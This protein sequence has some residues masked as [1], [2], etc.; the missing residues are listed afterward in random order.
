MPDLSVKT[1]LSDQRVRPSPGLRSLGVRSTRMLFVDADKDGISDPIEQL[2]AERFAPIIFIHP[3]EPNYPVSVEWLL[4]RTRLRYFEDCGPDKLEDVPNASPVGSQENL[5]GLPWAH[6]DDWGAGHPT[7]HCGGAP[8]HRRITSIEP[9]PESFGDQ[10]TFA[11]RDVQGNDRL[12]SLDPADWVT[13]VH[14]YPNDTGGITLQYWHLFAYNSLE[15]IVIGEHGGDWDGTVHVVLGPDLEP[16][17]AVYPR[18][19]ED[20]PGHV[21]DWGDL[22]L[23]KTTHPR[24]AIDAGG[25][26]SFKDIQDRLAFVN[27]RVPIAGFPIQAGVVAWFD[28]PDNPGSGAGRRTGGNVTGRG[29]IWET[30]SGGRVRSIGDIGHPAINATSGGLI[31]VGEYDPGVGQAAGFLAGNHEP[32]PLNNQRFIQYSGRWG[33]VGGTYNTGPRG[34]VFQGYDGANKRYTSWYFG[35]SNDPAKPLPDGS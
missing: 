32:L 26:G 2:L 15:V 31:N 28:D 3:D 34:P 33:D 5:L 11:L 13:Y 4:R 30:W 9:D 16:L 1:L 7:R 24:V 12:G 27:A 25:H 23:Y 8:E 17:R 19:H 10:T 22:H 29:T 35:A 20:K 14:V 6:P 21:F 18:H